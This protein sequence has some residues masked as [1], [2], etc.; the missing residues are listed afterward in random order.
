M[1]DC[2]ATYAYWDRDLLERDILINS[3]TGEPRPVTLE[4]LGTETIEVQGERVLA[5][6]LRLDEGTVAIDLWYE[7]TTSRWLRLDSRSEG[8]RMLRYLV[9]PEQRITH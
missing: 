7:A 8:G 1:E 4:D 6:R 2:A 3:Q 5:R 9:R